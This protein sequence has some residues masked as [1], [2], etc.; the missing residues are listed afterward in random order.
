MFKDL[1]GRPCDWVVVMEGYRAWK[2]WKKKVTLERDLDVI[3]SAL[4]HH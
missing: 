2:R 4:E 1:E 3:L